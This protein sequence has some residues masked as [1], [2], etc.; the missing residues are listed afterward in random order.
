MADQPA[1]S[2]AKDI[3]PMFTDMDVEHMKPFGIDLSSRDDVEANADNIYATVSDG[4]MPPRG[5][6]EERWST[7]MCERFKQWQTQGFPP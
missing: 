1:L 7:E 4:S 3:R 5:S 2:F 6:G